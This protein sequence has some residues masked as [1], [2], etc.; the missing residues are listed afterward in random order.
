MSSN[1]SPCFSVILLFSRGA[2][3]LK[4]VGKGTGMTLIQYGPKY[5]P[6]TVFL[7]KRCSENMQ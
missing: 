3:N 7:E 1:P 4:V 2:Q 6:N 5:I